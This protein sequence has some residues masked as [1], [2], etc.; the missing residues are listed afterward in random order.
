[1]QS[2]GTGYTFFWSEH[3]RKE[4]HEAGVGFAI[5]TGLVG[6][7]SGLP[8][9]IDLLMTLKLP[10]FGNQHTTIIS[11]YAITPVRAKFYNDLDNVIS[12]SSKLQAHHSR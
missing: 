1:M 2:V 10:L 8:K 4:M 12:A 5:K 11:A 6:K 3:K 9:G 7:L